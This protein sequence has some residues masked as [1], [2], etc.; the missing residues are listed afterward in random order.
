MSKRYF[1]VNPEWMRLVT[2]S[3][4]SP[5]FI[6][7]GKWLA[8]TT[9][10]DDTW[11]ICRLEKLVSWVDLKYTIENWIYFDSIWDNRASYTY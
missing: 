2:D 3:V 7:I 9:T 11:Q 8:W 1:K 10:A 4:T 6:Y 5:W